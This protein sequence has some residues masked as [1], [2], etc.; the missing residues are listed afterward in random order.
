MCIYI[1]IY[2]K[3]DIEP[4]GK[5]S[6]HKNKNYKEEYYICVL[7]RLRDAGAS[8]SVVNNLQHS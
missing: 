5:V 3:H 4:R 8:V 1:Y 2:M 7:C 6:E